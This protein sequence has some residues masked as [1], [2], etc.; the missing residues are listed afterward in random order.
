[1]EILPG[2]KVYRAYIGLIWFFPYYEQLDLSKTRDILQVGVDRL[3]AES[4]I[5]AGTLKEDADS[6]RVEHHDGT[7]VIVQQ[8]TAPY[9]LQE[10]SACGYDQNCFPRVFEDLP[11]L[12][13]DIDGL[14]V[15]VVRVTKLEC[16]ALAVAVLIHHVFADAAGAV[17][18]AHNLSMHC[19]NSHPS[20]PLC[21]NRDSLAYKI[22]SY[23][24]AAPACMKQAL[25]TDPL[26]FGA[27]NLSF[28][29]SMTRCQFRISKESLMQ[30]RNLID[31]GNPSTNSVV[32]ALLWRV[33]TRMLRKHGSKGHFTYAGGPVDMRNSIGPIFSNEQ[34]Y[35]GNL[36]QPLPMSAS[37]ELVLNKTLV[38]VA[39]YVQDYFKKEISPAILRWYMSG[40][41]HDIGGHLAKTDT[42]MLAFSN[43]RRPLANTN[44][45]CFGL[46]CPPLSVQLRS[47]DAPFMF[48]AIDDGCGGILINCN[49]P[50]SSRDAFS[51]DKE[52]A[53][54]ATLVY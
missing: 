6:V 24:P 34:F 27:S 3:I 10:I 23:K 39:L 51:S 44:N 54:F 8:H 53:D 42:P 20:T 26:A 11:G 16:G 40:A 22:S 18:V 35:I 33:W 49:L 9:S 47:F 15:L 30:F 48:F 19:D 21:Y 25:K 4:T 7:S 36:I 52:F 43:M 37:V 31:V 28:Q 32:L 12:T 14:P 29:G 38:E 1:M 13:P 41:D 50:V 2:E 45:M 17:A 5:L 46:E